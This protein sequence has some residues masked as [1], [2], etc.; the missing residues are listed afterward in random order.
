[1][2][3]FKADVPGSYIL[4]DHSMV[5]ASDKDAIGKGE[6]R[7]NGNLFG[8]PPVGAIQSYVETNPT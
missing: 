7:Q 8:T 3:E 5:R 1:M 6:S 2:V 4:V